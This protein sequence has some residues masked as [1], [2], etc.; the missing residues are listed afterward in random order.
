MCLALS[1]AFA[2]AP[3]SAQIASPEAADAPR[4]DIFEYQI[5]GNSRLADIDIERAVMPYLGE[6]KS[7][8]E[9][10]AARAEL[11]R[12]YHD[13]GYLTV[14]VSIP[15]QNVDSGV[16]AL[17]VV[18]AT[19]D[20]LRVKGS[21][22]HTLSGIKAQVPE[23]AEGNVPN[24]NQMQAQ[25]GT[26]N[27]GADMKVTPVLLAGKV[28][29]TVEVHLDVED[30]L[31]LHGSVEL[32]NRQSPNTSEARLSASLRYDNLWQLGH[33]IG[34][35]VQTSPQ[36][37]DEVKVLS[38]TYVMPLGKDGDAL[39]LY[40]V[41]SR[42]SVASLANSPGLGVLGNVDI[43]GL[44]YAL[45]AASSDDFAY[46]LSGGLDFKN[47]KQ[48]VS[49]VGAGSVE[50]PIKYVPLVATYTAN[51]FGKNTLTTFDATATLGLRSFFGNNDAEFGGKR[52]GASADY[53][54]LRTG[55]SRVQPIGRWS[56]SGKVEM[57]LASGPLVSNEQFTAGGAES[58]RGYLE[59]ERA[60]DSAL[61]ASLELRT[62]QFKP[63]GET[64]L[65]AVTALAFA[66]AARLRTFEAVSPQPAI[67]QIRGAGIGMRVSAPRALALE[68]DWAH[69][70]D[71]G[72]VTKAGS[73]RV[74]A[75][76]IWDY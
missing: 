19:V 66:D 8:V 71:D 15:E 55:L 57:Q 70:F 27:R 13:A 4:F 39:T 6:R 22:Y 60:G 33:S 16:V 59:G 9:V 69:A 68:L 56:V 49:V 58:V 24:F 18:E 42:S 28:P 74:H 3:V 26:V 23:L 45:P 76:L 75:R 61:R 46:T 54:A 30:K 14:V 36:K 5:D 25:L 64:S 73:N 72:D 38:G 62:P 52:F 21:E 37:T 51:W 63:A 2:V 17:H 40:A 53:L 31:P 1:L 48:A 44:R 65:W 34:V 11:E 32:S 35:S 47:V 10:E 67:Q 7:L 43:F 50:T 20:R 29:G 41:R 12:T